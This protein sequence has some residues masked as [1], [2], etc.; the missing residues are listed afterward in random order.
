MTLETLKQFVSVDLARLT[1][2]E[3]WIEN[4]KLFATD[5]KILVMTDLI[6]GFTR[7]NTLPPPPTNIKFVM[8]DFP[9]DPSAHKWEP[10]PKVERP[11]VACGD[12]GGSGTHACSCGNV[13]PCPDCESGKT[14]DTKK[15]RE[16]GTRLIADHYLAKIAAL[17]NCEVCVEGNQLDPMPFRFDGGIG[18]LMPIRKR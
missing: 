8:A 4:G 5:G 14:V 18:L 16:V 3:P 11:M 9:N 2:T 17:P 7:T 12:C 15:N 1:I 13:H 6:D 10:A